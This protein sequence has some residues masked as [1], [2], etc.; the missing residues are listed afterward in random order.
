MAKRRHKKTIAGNAKKRKENAS[1]TTT[2]STALMPVGSLMSDD[3]AIEVLLRLPPKAVTRFRCVSPAWRDLIS[4]NGFK[5][6]YHDAAAVA[7]AAAN[8][9]PRFVFVPADPESNERRCDT[10]SWCSIVKA[11]PAHS[12]G[13]ATAGK[14]CLGV[15]LLGMPSNGLFFL[16]N[17]STGGLLRL[18]PRRPACYIH[19]A[20]LGYHAATGEH[21][22][23]LLEHAEGQSVSAPNLQGHVLTVGARRRSWRA[24]RGKRSAAIR[25][26]VVPT[27]TDPV[28]ADGCLHFML[29]P[30]YWLRDEP[31]GILSFSLGGESFS[32]IPPPPFAAADAVK[33]SKDHLK[34]D[35]DAA[36]D[37]QE[38]KAPAGTT[39]A[40]LDGSLCMVRDRRTDAM[41]TLEVWKLH[42]GSTG[43]W[44]LDYTIDLVSDLLKLPRVVVPL[45]YIMDDG[46]TRKILLA[47]TLRKAHLYD[48][49]TKKLHT[50][51]SNAKGAPMCPVFY[52]DSI[53]SMAGMEY[54][55]AYCRKNRITLPKNNGM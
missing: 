21:K 33:Y 49:S 32:R 12:P 46:E 2:T 51:A 38:V 29:S 42:A 20:S 36:E 23:L 28:F 9:V 41:D 37:S 4:S 48:P 47:T 52:Q 27:G 53:V 31:Q 8:A 26:V 17:P 14:P 22:V 25:D 11:Y 40:E 7:A 39:L 30:K 16:C 3:M 6:Q 10:P 24:P 35:P 55:T 15:F 19:S 54:G 5:Q 45:C 34:P 18:P 50:V 1:T 44:S 43:S 13:V